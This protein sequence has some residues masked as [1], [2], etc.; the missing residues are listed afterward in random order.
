M[1]GRVSET[2][3]ELGAPAGAPQESGVLQELGAPAEVPQESG[4]LREPCRSQEHLREPRRSLESC[5][6]P[7]GVWSPAGVRSPAGFWSP[8]GVL[9]ES[10]PVSPKKHI[11][12]QQQQGVNVA[13]VSPQWFF[14]QRVQFTVFIHWW[15][16]TRTCTRKTTD[17]K[18]GSL[19]PRLW[20]VLRVLVAVRAEWCRG[21]LW[22][23]EIHPRLPAVSGPPGEPVQLS[24]RAVG[25]SSSS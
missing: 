22:M 8:A 15:Y 11:R 2:P 9:Q 1:H 12:N 17:P 16:R 6:S 21:H 25:Q 5:R 18:S 7:A 23:D 3:Q 20:Q 19:P 14:Q 13:H 4:A 24:S 10:G